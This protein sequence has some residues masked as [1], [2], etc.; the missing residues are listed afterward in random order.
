MTDKMRSY[1]EALAARYGWDASRNEE[2]EFEDEQVEDAFA[3]FR[4]GSEWQAAQRQ[5]GEAK[6]GH[7]WDDAGERCLK[8]GDKD[9]FAGPECD[10]D[11]PQPAVPESDWTPRSERMPAEDEIDCKG[12]LW[13]YHIDGNVHIV[14]AMAI[15]V[16][17][18]WTHW[19]PTGL[20]RPEPPEDV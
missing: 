19:K 20:K 15:C 10:A 7:S 2:G 12:T 14:G 1:F 8:C 5:G 17:P 11:R 4:R 3:L 6:R 16:H 13:G 18:C 9:W